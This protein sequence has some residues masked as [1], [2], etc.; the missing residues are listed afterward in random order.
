[1][2]HLR[3]FASRSLMCVCVYILCDFSGVF[4]LLTQP[5]FFISFPLFAACFQTH[6]QLST[7][8][9]QTFHCCYMCMIK[10]TQSFTC[11]SDTL[12]ISCDVKVLI[13]DYGG[14]KYTGIKT[15]IQLEKFSKDHNDICKRYL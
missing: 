1:M 13:W 3:L 8:V 12:D 6:C 4:L 14:L 7:L 11:F 5:V 9:H 15:I 10:L 2:F